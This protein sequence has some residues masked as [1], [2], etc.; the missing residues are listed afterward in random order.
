MH[1]SKYF[2][3]GEIDKCIKTSPSYKSAGYDLITGNLLTTPKKSFFNA[4]IYFNAILRLSYF[5]LQWKHSTLIL[6]HK[7]NKPQELS[8]SY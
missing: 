2:S 6:I 8:S 4:Y 3:P 1:P 7:P 5:T